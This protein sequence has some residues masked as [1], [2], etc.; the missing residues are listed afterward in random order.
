MIAINTQ[1]IENAILSFKKE[2]EDDY[3]LTLRQLEKDY[4]SYFK[5]FSRDEQVFFRK[6]LYYTRDHNIII[7]SNSEIENIKN[8]IGEIPKSHFKKNIRNKIISLKDLINN[9]LNY[10]NKENLFI[11]NIFNTL[12]SNLAY[13]VILNLQ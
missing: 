7:L 9:T 3:K 10:K 6:F 1:I 2:I 8:L 13:T 5:D 11:H 4:R 12:V